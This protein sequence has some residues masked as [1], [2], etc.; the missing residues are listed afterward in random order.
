P[1]S[2]ALDLYRGMLEDAFAVTAN[3]EVEERYVYW[4]GAPAACDGLAMPP[5][6]RAREQQGG[7]LGERIERAF[8]DLLA[9]P[10]DH[11]VIVGADCPALDASALDDAFD[12]LA[13][14]EGVLGPARDG[15]YYLVGLRCRAPGLFRDID[16]STSRVLDQTLQRATEAGLTIAR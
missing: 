14:R 6:F 12:A 15:G 11:A 5:G 3:A 1:P 13:T 7:D 8:D 2:L 10:Q 16:W 4:A 9:S